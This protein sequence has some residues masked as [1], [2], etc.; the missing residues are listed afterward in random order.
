MDGLFHGKHYFL[1]DDLGGGSPYFW[2][3]THLALFC[4]ALWHVH[5]TS[6][7]TVWKLL[8]QRWSPR[9][10]WDVFFWKC[11]APSWQRKKDP[12]ERSLVGKKFEF[13]GL[14]LK[15]RKTGSL[16]TPKENWHLGRDLCK[17]LKKGWYKYLATKDRWKT[18]DLGLGSFILDHS[19]LQVLNDDAIS[20]GLWQFIQPYFFKAL[21]SDGCRSS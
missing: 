20:R 2:F 16:K 19:N 21:H 12:Q 5:F 18:I 3:N 4:M 1:M 7:R 8:P 15:D 17:F 14:F 10:R 11:P 13:L 6:H 9:L